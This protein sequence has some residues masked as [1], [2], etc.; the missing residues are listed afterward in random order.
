M[1]T[2]RH[3]HRLDARRL[4]TRPV[5]TGLSVEDFQTILSVMRSPSST[6]GRWTEQRVARELEAWFAQRCFDEWP[7]YRTFVK[8]GRKT[9]HA[10]LMR[11]GGAQRWA[12]ELGVPVPD[13][14]QVAP[15][16]DDEV[17]AALRQVL[18]EHPQQRFPSHDWL[19]AHGPRGLAAAVRRTGGVAHWALVLG[20]P[21][22]AP[23][24]WTDELIE[25][26][27]RRV[28]A[29]ATHWP[30]RAHFEAAH[31]SALLQAVYQGHGSRWWA[32]RLGLATDGL[33]PRRAPSHRS[34]LDAP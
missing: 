12:L 6:P 23:V 5:S 25:A 32:E 26:E 17:L 15:L 22:P 1:S 24:R 3:S 21:A 31:A 4:A 7:T 29:G 2:R 8:D 30:S 33:R 28:C 10:A 14:R 18:A 11:Y 20:M 27:L 19:M 34:S 13:R 16:R 9:L